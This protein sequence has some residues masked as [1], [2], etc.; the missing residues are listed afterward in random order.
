MA[1]RRRAE[2]TSCYARGLFRL[3]CIHTSPDPILAD[4]AK[5]RFVIPFL[6]LSAGDVVLSELIGV[7]STG[8]VASE[9]PFLEVNMP[10]IFLNTVCVLAASI[11]IASNASAGPRDEYYAPYPRANHYA[12]PTYYAPRTYGYQAPPVSYYAPPEPAWVTLRPSSCGQYRFW[13]GQYCAD[14]RYEPPYLGPRW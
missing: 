8:G 5:Q 9:G 2:P 14:A 10:R 4:S 12:S 7:S 1:E 13:N 11:L 6:T 3:C